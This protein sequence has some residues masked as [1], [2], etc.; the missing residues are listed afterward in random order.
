VW[1]SE[2][3]ED[4]ALI[5]EALRSAGRNVRLRVA[6]RG[7]ARQLVSLAQENASLALEARLAKR[8]GRRAHYEP[9]AHDLQRVLGLE[10]PPLRIVGFDV[11]NLGETDA[12]AS[13]VV[14]ENGGMRRGEYKRLRMR[15]TGPD[16]FAMMREAVGRYFAR[17]AAGEW[18]VPDLILIDG[19][20]GQVGAAASALAG[21]SLPALPL[22]GLAK[23]EETIVLADGRTVSLPRRSPALR[24]LQR[25]RDEA[26]R[27]AVSYHRG[28]R[29]RRTVRSALDTI[30][31]IGPARRRALLAA[32]GSVA[33]VR[34]ASVEALM[35]RARLPRLLAERIRDH[36]SEPQTPAGPREGAAAPQPEPE[37]GDP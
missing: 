19:G 10:R 8:G 24:L 11:S 36:W 23:R 5:E 21:L 28:L 9:E 14:A 30:P 4:A 25:V 33:A 22:I 2:P 16:D 27:F 35:E 29:T 34:G 18:P 6:R 31:G 26:H 7:R 15:G 17:V 13:A 37:A 3:I 1:L 32:F 12:V 20:I